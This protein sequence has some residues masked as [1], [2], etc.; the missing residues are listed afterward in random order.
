MGLWQSM[1]TTIPLVNSRDVLARIGVRCVWCTLPY[2]AF[3]LA[4]AVFDPS[5]SV[6]TPLSFFMLALP[7]LGGLLDSYRIKRKSSPP[8]A[9]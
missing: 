7:I 6:A 5:R 4:W 9:A 3:I 2:F 1:T 8:A